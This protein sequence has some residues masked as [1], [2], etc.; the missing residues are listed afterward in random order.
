MWQISNTKIVLQQGDITEFSGEAIVN[1]ANTSLILGAGVAGAIKK[2]G[3]KTIQDECNEIGQIQLGGAAITTGGDLKVR[4]VIHAASM[5]LGGKT[6]EESLRDSLENSLKEG[7]SA[8][9]SSIAFPA[10]GTGIAGFPLEKCAN[11]MINT[12]KEY[13][14]N[15]QH[16]YDLIEV[17]LYS[18]KDYQRFMSIFEEFFTYN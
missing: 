13:L 10:I 9:I 16:Y 4:Y 12:F 15:E 3:G 5:H 1:A 17:F 6:T 2:K 14:T 8:R 18:K 11:I 7:A